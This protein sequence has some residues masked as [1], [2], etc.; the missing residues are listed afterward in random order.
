MG[1]LL[2]DG[3]CEFQGKMKEPEKKALALARG[4]NAKFV[5]IPTAAAPDNHFDSNDDGI[6]VTL[7]PVC[8]D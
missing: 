2:L 1:F 6:Y 7:R 8:S 5:I 4:K 3:G